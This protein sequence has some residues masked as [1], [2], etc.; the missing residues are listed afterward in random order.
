VE[1]AA[2]CAVAVG[3]LLWCERRDLVPG[4]WVAKLGASTLFLVA[5]LRWGALDTRY[6]QLVL[7]ALA[8]CWLGDALLIPRDSPRL[9]RAGIASFLIGHLAYA[10][11]FL[12]HST[13][14][15]AVALGGVA[16]G[17]AAW[18][19]HAW[20]R[21]HL[22]ADFAIPVTA[23]LGVIS[24]MVVAALGNAAARGE[25]AVALG[26][27]LFAVSDVSVARDRFVAPGFANAAWGLPLYYAAQLVLASTV[28]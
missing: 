16:V 18:R 8:F 2:A 26:A 11:A 3:L 19:V 27:L 1:I 14:P 13:V 6:G 21:P 17:I 15:A 28:R 5:A 9:F 12:D 25:V 24:A 4:I 23:Y 22:S 20:L 7:A 10:A